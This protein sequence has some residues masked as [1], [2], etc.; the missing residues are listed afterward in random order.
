MKGNVKIIAQ[1]RMSSS[2]LPEKVLRVIDDKTI[3]GHLVTR[4][5]KAKTIDD[6]IIATSNDKSDDLIEKECKKYN[7]KCFR[8]SLNDVLARFYY[9]AKEYNAQNIL[10]ICCDSPL[11]DWDMV[12]AVVKYYLENEYDIILN[13]KVPIGFAFEVFSFEKLEDAFLNAKNDYH[14]E[15]VTPYIYEN[16]DKCYLYEND[17]D[18]SKYRLTLDT[19]KDFELLQ[20]VFKNL[21]KG[22][23][24]F[25]MKDVVSLLQQKPELYNI[26]KEVVQKSKA[27]DYVKNKNNS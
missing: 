21:Y 11:I 20:E 19:E 13:T 7:V 16:T 4:L 1:A 18:Y 6:I 25:Y 14:R 23:H 12:D 10:R 9:A 26:N 5:K 24:N 27:I 15:H 8:G 3:I 22:E 2:R 17:I